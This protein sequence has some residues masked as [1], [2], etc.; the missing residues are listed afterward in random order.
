MVG[1]SPWDAHAAARVDMP[2]VLVRCGGFGE[3]ALR[4]ADPVRVVDAPADLIGQL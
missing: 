4:E 2:C 1:D 3:P